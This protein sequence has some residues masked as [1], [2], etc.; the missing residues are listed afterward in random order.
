MLPIQ[1]LGI[2]EDYQELPKQH[3]ELREA[4]IDSFE[5]INRFSRKVWELCTFTKEQ[6]ME[7]RREEVAFR[8]KEKKKG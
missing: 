4:I 3:I 6:Y 8:K 7:R 1:R 2:D 5:V